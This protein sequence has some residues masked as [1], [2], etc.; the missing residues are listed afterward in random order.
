MTVHLFSLCKLLVSHNYSES[1]DEIHMQILPCM[2][3]IGWL[4]DESGVLGRPMRLESCWWDGL[5]Q[6]PGAE[7]T[8]HTREAVVSQGSQDD[9]DEWDDKRGTRTFSSR[10][11]GT[12]TSGTNRDQTTQIQLYIQPVCFIPP[13]CAFSLTFLAFYVTN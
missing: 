1:R 2:G 11:V 13:K 12:E 9:R 5:V 8:S 4:R 3:V 6:C 7:I 10:I